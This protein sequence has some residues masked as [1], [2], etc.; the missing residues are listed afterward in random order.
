MYKIDV[1]LENQATTTTTKLLCRVNGLGTEELL[2]RSRETHH[3]NELSKFGQGPKV[4]FTFNN[5]FVYSFLPGRCLRVDE[6]PTFAPQIA[7]QMFQFHQMDIDAPDRNES[8]L[9]RMTHKWFRDL[10]ELQRGIS[11]DV[12]QKVEQFQLDTMERELAE[13]ERLAKRYDCDIV[14][15]HNDL[16]AYNIILNEDTQSIHFIDYEYC[17]YNYR[18][19]DIGNHFCEYGARID[20]E[21]YPSVDMQRRFI[22][23]Y[24][25][26]WT[27][28]GEDEASSSP[29]R[30]EQ[31]REQLRVEANFF[32]LLVNLAWGT[33]AIPQALNSTIK[34]DYWRYG[35]EKYA[36]Y[37]AKREQHMREFIDFYE[38]K[39]QRQ[40]QQQQQEA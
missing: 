18:A 6:M 12:K 20:P 21:L 1:T 2:D 10:H 36:W 25:E 29:D 13:L 8:N 32:A 30:M 37:W 4:Y 27:E 19:F 23:Y 31:L 34:Y 17:G 3:M 38:A 24:V 22:Q 28:S 33:W 7:R 9:F 16:L 5:G 35:M 14:F 26:Q 39:Q 40:Q 15:C 11:G